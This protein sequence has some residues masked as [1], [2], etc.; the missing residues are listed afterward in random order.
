MTDTHHDPDGVPEVQCPACGATIRARLADQP[1]PH[2]RVTYNKPDD[3]LGP[4]FALGAVDE[5]VLTSADLHL[6]M[7]D[8]A[9]AYL[10]V[11][12]PHWQV[13]G[14]VCA[15]PTTRAERRQVL[16][17]GDDRLRDHLWSLLPW[18]ST[19]W[20]VPVWRRPTSALRTWWAAR[21]AA[22][23]VLDVRVEDDDL[24]HGRDD[25]EETEH[26]RL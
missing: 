4:E 15:R 22:R 16:K 5:I 24:G 2:D 1:R 19:T 20:F 7:L 6:E 26:A 25:T 8:D 21:T 13:E 10:S 17:H 14:R 3:W 11:R 18:S 9:T 12:A 23:A